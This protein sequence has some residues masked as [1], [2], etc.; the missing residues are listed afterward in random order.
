MSVTKR[1]ETFRVLIAGSVVATQPEM[2]DIDSELKELAV[3]SRV[4]RRRR[5]YLLQVL[6]TTRTLDTFL[7]SFT[8]HHGCKVSGKSLGRYLVALRDHNLKHLRALTEAER[9]QFQDAIV[10]LRNTYMHAA[11]RFPATDAEISKLL[12]DMHACLSCVVAL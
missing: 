9:K 1:A 8:S 4:W 12:S 5:K 3:S 11:G 7:V 6:H 2:T 10:D